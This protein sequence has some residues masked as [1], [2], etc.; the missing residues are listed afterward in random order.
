MAGR[1]ERL[2]PLEIE[3][4]EPSVQG[5]AEHP[6]RTMTRR[7]AGLLPEPWDHEARATV[8]AYFD[9]LAPDW[10][11][12]SS[13]QRDRVVA[14]ALERG[15]PDVGAAETCLEVGSGIGSYTPM[16]ATR[17]NRVLAVELS[18]EMLRAAPADVGHRVRAD[19]SRLPITDGGADA[20]VLVN[21]FLFP[22]EVDR[23]LAPDGVV[24]WVNS[25][26][27]AT[28]IHLTGDEVVEALPGR[29]E[30]VTSGAGI[31]LWNVLHRSAG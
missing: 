10:H 26:G 3:G 12:R 31:G 28:P 1:L 6:M 20:V 23:V 24:V 17:W 4:H 5:G 13:P 14:D 7:A 15:L 29:W 27:T 19:G 16:L 18:M 2:P 21:C 22:A 30:G 11:T 25:S 8:A 9:D